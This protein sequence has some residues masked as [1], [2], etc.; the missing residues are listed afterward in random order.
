MG[1]LLATLLLP[2]GCLSCAF[3]EAGVSFSGVAYQVTFSF[4]AASNAY[5]DNM[6]FGSAHPGGDNSSTPEP[7]TLALL[8]T[9]LFGS[10]RFTKRKL[11]TKNRHD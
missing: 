11:L 2:S 6:T 7:G 9:G 3:K 1:A 4:P 5:Y 10:L 8:G